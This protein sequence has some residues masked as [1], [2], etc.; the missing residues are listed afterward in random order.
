MLDILDL[1]LDLILGRDILPRSEE[2]SLVHLSILHEQD[3]DGNHTGEVEHV[4]AVLH[5]HLQK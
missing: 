3:M 2:H 4:Y 5:C 1:I